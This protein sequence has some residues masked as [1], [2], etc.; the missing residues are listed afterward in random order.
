MT[1][2]MKMLDSAIRE[3]Y[4]KVKKVLAEETLLE[5]MCSYYLGKLAA[6]DNILFFIWG[7]EKT[8]K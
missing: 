5:F 2:E 6:Y 8:A 7:G 3:C 4:D 1:P